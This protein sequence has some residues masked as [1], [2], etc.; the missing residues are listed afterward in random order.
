MMISCAES[1]RN[2]GTRSVTCCCVVSAQR[3][4]RRA[5]NAQAS[6]ARAAHHELVDVS[7]ELELLRG[8]SLLACDRR[9]GEEERDKRNE[10]NVQQHRAMTC[11]RARGCRTQSGSAIRMAAVRLLCVPGARS[12]QRAERERSAAAVGCSASVLDG[13]ERRA[14][15]IRLPGMLSI[16]TCQPPLGCGGSPLTCQLTILHNIT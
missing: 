2:D 8:G 10:A 16:L 7:L 5:S 6:Q 15:R 4:G 3:C 13:R 14:R 9:S 12:S 1:A 11:R